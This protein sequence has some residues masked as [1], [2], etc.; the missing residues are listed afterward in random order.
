MKGA[1]EVS[2]PYTGGC[3]CGRIRYE[4]RG[5]P[6]TLYCCHCTECQRQS[7]SAFGMSM[8][9]LTRDLA[10]VQGEPQEWRRRAASG[11]EVICRFCPDC[12]SR[13]F[14]NPTRNLKV[15]NVKPGTLDDTQ[16]LQ[17]VGHLWTRSAQPW[18]HIDV[19]TLSYQEQPVDFAP[20]FARWREG[21]N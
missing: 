8:V 21:G 11:G 19:D 20:L 13:L 17:P 3:Q 14:H 18:V 2:A 6:L 4:I 7:S 5:E 15:T 10:I 1:S 12:G 16:W 9:V